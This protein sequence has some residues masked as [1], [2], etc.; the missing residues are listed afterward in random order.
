MSKTKIV[1][2]LGL[3]ALV[4]VLS[5]HAAAPVQA[6]AG[7]P[8]PGLYVTDLAISPNPPTVGST[9]TFT[10]SF[11]NTS[12]GPLTFDWRVLIYQ[13]DTPNKSYSD[14]TLGNTIFPT[15]A[16][17]VTSLGDWNLPLG[18]PCNWYFARVVFEDANNNQIPFTTP[19]GK[20]FEKGFTTCP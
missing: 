20:V 18:T 19:D 10:P 17:T 8:A 3:L 12:N 11:L 9:F 5:V 7:T 2:T 4:L 16:S 15:G 13:A 6:Q 14:T 1:L